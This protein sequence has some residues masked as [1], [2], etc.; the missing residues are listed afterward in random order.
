MKLE[1]VKETQWD[2]EGAWYCI[3]L[4]ETYIV[5]SSNQEKIDRIFAEAISDPENYFKTKKE[6]LISAEINVPL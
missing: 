1:M 5:G 4:D 6:V 2:K 3:Y